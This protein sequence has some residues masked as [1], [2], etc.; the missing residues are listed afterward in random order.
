MYQ[1]IPLWERN[2]FVGIF[3]TT[4]EKKLKKIIPKEEYENFVYNLDGE[5]C[6]NLKHMGDFLTVV[7]HSIIDLYNHELDN[8]SAMDTISLGFK[9]IIF[10]NIEK[11][12]NKRIE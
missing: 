9:E 12:E 7:T 1:G 5:N 10:Q 8:K 4:K 3:P 11:K 6:I 2:Y